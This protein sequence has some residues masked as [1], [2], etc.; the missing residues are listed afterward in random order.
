VTQSEPSR[1]ESPA[2]PPPAASSAFSS[3]SSAE[4]KGVNGLA[5][6]ALVLGVV[7]FVGFPLVPSVLAI[8]LGLRAR[9]QIESGPPA[10]GRALAEAGIVL[11]WAAIALLVLSAAGLVAVFSVVKVG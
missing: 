9:R 6:A 3:A 10:R 11:G 1:S 4:G 8:I 2:P 7:G 5:V